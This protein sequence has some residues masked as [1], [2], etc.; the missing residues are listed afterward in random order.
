MALDKKLSDICERLE[1]TVREDDN[2]TIELAKFSP[3]GEDFNI[4]VDSKDFIQNV[5]EYVAGWDIDEHIEMWIDAR[6]NGV[7][8]VPS[9]RELVCDAE[10]I[11]KMLQELAAALAKEEAV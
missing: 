10:A 7:K 3:A 9:T 4:C 6:R 2:G 8:G 5:K 1:W 11:D